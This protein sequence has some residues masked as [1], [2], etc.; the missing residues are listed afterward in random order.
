M[1]SAR[2]IFLDR[3]GVIN[4]NRSGYVTTWD[5]FQFLPGA[6]RAIAR[7]TEAGCRVFVITNQACVGKGIVPAEA[8][9][10]IHRRMVREVERAGGR[11]EAVLW[12][13]HRPDVHCECRKPA[14]GLLLRAQAEYGVELASAAFVGDS[15]GDVRA[16]AAA[17]VP[18]ILVLSGLGWHTAMGI[19]SETLL[20]CQV[21]LNLPH[22]T[23]L[24]LSSPASTI[25]RAAWLATIVGGARAIG[26]HAALKPR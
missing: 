22:A 11:I 10:D 4:R 21:A 18:S 15:V 7:M 23:R 17:G 8:I 16:A 1:P 14:P 20:C 19:T 26:A 12:C 3:D 25:R 5:E 6:C 9:E 13:P 2:T 24:L